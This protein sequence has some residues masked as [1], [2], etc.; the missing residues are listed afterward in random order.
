M[1]RRK[2][3]WFVTLLLFA[4][5]LSLVG[6]GGRGAP[7]EGGSTE[8]PIK[9]EANLEEENTEEPV[10]EEA[11]PGAP[12]AAPTAAV[13]SEEQVELAEP[14]TVMAAAQVIDLRHLHRLES[15]TAPN[16]KQVGYLS[17]SAPTEMDTAI[18]FHRNQLI[19]LGWQEEP[20]QEVRVDNVSQKIASFTF[21]KEGFQL[22]LEVMELAD[23]DEVIH[24]TLANRGNVDARGLPRLPEA[25]LISEPKGSTL[26]YVTEV[27]MDQVADFARKELVAL[28]WQEYTDAM[29]AQASLGAEEGASP[30]TYSLHFIQNGI[31]LS[32][33]IFTADTPQQAGKTSVSYDLRLAA[34]DLP[35][36]ADALEIQLNNSGY[37]YTNDFFVSYTTPSDLETVLTF[38]RQ[39]LADLDWQVQGQEVALSPTQTLLGF[40]RAEEE[41]PLLLS[42]SQTEKKQ[43][44]V[45]LG[46]TSMETELVAEETSPSEE[47]SVPPDEMA[48][49]ENGSVLSAQTLPI[50]E[51]VQEP[52]FDADF[53]Q[54]TYTSPSTIESLVEFYR[55]ELPAQGW[56]EDETFSVIEESMALLSFDQGDASLTFTFFNIGLGE[57]T[58][59]TIDASGLA[60]DTGTPGVE[61]EAETPSLEEE[62]EEGLGFDI[63]EWPIPAEAEEVEI[64]WDELSYLVPWD[65]AAVADFYGPTYAS[66]DLDT[67]CF[68]DLADFTSI[69]CSTSN[70]QLSV[71]MHLFE[72]M[73]GRTEVTFN[74]YDFSGGSFDEPANKPETLALGTEEGLPVPNDFSYESGELSEYRKKMSGSSAADLTALVELYR[75]ELP[76]QGWQETLP[77]SPTEGSEEARL[78][79]EQPGEIL[80]I[81]LSQT[82]DG[83]EISLLQKS[84][85]AA[86]AAGLIPPAGQVRLY[87]GNMNTGDVTVTLNQQTIKVAPTT[88]EAQPEDMA[89]LDLAPGQ[90]S[91]TLTI[92]GEGEMSDSI[93]VGPDESWVLIIG[94]G[95][96]FPIQAY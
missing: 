88:P 41:Q 81:E 61:E 87:F 84:P 34:T 63:N 58:E 70:G 72:Q 16:V 45:T 31:D 77:S 69:S 26:V 18:D 10:K 55:Q 79:F 92:P 83:T 15:A 23:N 32:V 37:A 35:I 47:E 93:E 14:A 7:S 95:G 38:Y 52:L 51:D 36:M 11:K 96:A 71:S 50:P 66:Y 30:D 76:A 21:N 29:F 28:G 67:S 59:V 9:E 85:D 73:D 5:L 48:E 82:A 65:F 90:H 6:C 60:W 24:I 1:E 80:T 39:T 27:K 19:D 43:T 62:A 89:Y 74:I 3:T 22:D 78:I 40:E 68:D 91:Y 56:Q 20:E 8:E 42:L 13:Q 46:S 57:D 86:R 33:T 64:N 25:E 12:V 49:V 44:Q 2:S 4:L 94:P 75:S 17:Y 53:E 54:I